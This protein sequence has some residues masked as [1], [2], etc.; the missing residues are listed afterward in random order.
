MKK[1]IFFFILIFFLILFQGLGAQETD[2][3]QKQADT[4]KQEIK[5]E[6]QTNI[7]AFAKLFLG[8]DL[9]VR[10]PREKATILKENT[11][12]IGARVEWT[13]TYGISPSWF[14]LP[15]E[16][17]KKSRIGNPCIYHLI[18]PEVSGY[19]DLSDKSILEGPQKMTLRQMTWGLPPQC[20]VHVKMKLEDV[21]AMILKNGMPY[22]TVEGTEL[23]VET[24]SQKCEWPEYNIQI[25]DHYVLSG[26]EIEVIN[27]HVFPV[28]VGLRSGDYGVDFIVPAKGEASILVPGGEY[29]AFFQYA[30]DPESL[31]QGDRVHLLGSGVQIR[32]MEAGDYLI[33]KIKLK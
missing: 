30:A 28:K 16:I 8:D 1:N 3:E 2:K 4:K 21:S 25:S 27:G 32:L 20:D 29:D 11:E 7:E 13:L 12:V 23:E 10:A 24:A 26:F 6:W 19:L 17:Q 5:E 33:R 31:Y 15:K 18:G 14:G 9:K 22:M